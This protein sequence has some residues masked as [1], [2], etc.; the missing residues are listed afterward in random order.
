MPVKAR[1]KHAGA[2]DPGR[3]RSNNEDAL[4]ADPDRGIFLVVDGIG[5]HNAGEQAAAIAVERV[6]ARLER[7]TGTAEQ[8]IREAIT[9]ANNEILQASGKNSEWAGMACV[10]T[11]VLLDNGDAVVGHVGDSRLYEIRGGDI[12]KLT[13]DHSPVGEREDS[14]ELSE[15]EAM[16]HPRRNEVYRDVGSEQHSPDDQDFIE[17][18][19]LPFESDT[20]LLLCSDG[21]SDQVP[22]REIR[23]AVERH[24]GAP[25]A[26]VNELVAAAN[27]A[28]GKDNVTVLLIEGEDFLAAPAPARKGTSL[29][30]RFF[31]FVAGL[32]AAT[33]AGWFTRGMWQ[34]APIEIPPR[35]IAVNTSIAAAMSEARPGDTVIVPAGEY[36]EQVK[37]KDGVTLRARVPREPVLRAAAMSS[38][39]AV[40]ADHVAGARLSGFR[41]L[42]DAG[43]P[44][45]VGIEVQDS[46]VEIDDVEV[47]GAGIG[48]E[49]R[50][51]ASPVLRA[52][53]I[54][55][56]ATE[57]VLILGPS[58]PWLSHN[59]IQANKV[60]GVAAREGGRPSL[61]GNVIDRNPLDVPGDAAEI[62]L[63]NHFLEPPKPAAGRGRR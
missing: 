46:T 60:A 21:L 30:Q 53:A 23:T 55:E 6:R 11:L 22:S 35:T 16:R 26:A 59:L 20:A 24:A 38:G 5:G 28:G 27:R 44:L 56:C 63:Q 42:A 19:R 10:L 18:L 45:N 41:I 7:Q 52:N 17:V 58:K 62:K 14:R 29:A 25:E 61:L 33:V 31:M 47:K 34:P 36:R 43:M 9:M 40:V 48:I 2:S 39:P 32:L 3:V 15:T 37:L 51:S 13:H 50:G 57:G 8:R 12:R 4:Y 1:I 54:R 49:I